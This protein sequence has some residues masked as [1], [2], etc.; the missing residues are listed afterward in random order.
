[1]VRDWIWKH[2]CTFETMVFSYRCPSHRRDRFFN[3]STFL[4]VENMGMNRG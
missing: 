3:R 2:G 1:M 4:L